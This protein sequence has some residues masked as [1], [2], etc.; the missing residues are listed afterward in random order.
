MPL[1]PVIPTYWVT[2]GEL[3]EIDRLR[4]WRDAAHLGAC[5]AFML[6]LG[7]IAA[8]LLLLF[9][10]GWEGLGWN[11]PAQ[12]AGGLAAAAVIQRFKLR[13]ALRIRLICARIRERGHERP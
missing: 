3:R 12:G 4:W 2:E 11:V 1:P 9:F 13:C 5:M 8:S 10:F 6:G 7:G